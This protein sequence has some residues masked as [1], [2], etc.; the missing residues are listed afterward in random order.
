ML[1]KYIPFMVK[2]MCPKHSPY[3]ITSKDVTFQHF[4]KSLSLKISTKPLHN[5]NVNI[6]HLSHAPHD[7]EFLCS[8]ETLQHDA[9]GH[10]DVVF[11]DVIS[12]MH[13]SVRLCHTDHGLNVTH[14]DGNASGGLIN[15]E[16]DN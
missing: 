15:R 14:S 3:W 16:K 10:V 11:V 9:D 7:A 2:A 1:A 5:K 13:A 12:Q 8:D 4:I 6:P